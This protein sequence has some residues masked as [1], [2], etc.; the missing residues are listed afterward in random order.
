MK[1]II[2]LIALMIGSVVHA[3]SDKAAFMGIEPG[4]AS[5]QVATKKLNAKYTREGDG[6]QVYDS[7]SSGDIMPQSKSI[8]LFCRDGVA[9]VISVAFPKGGVDASLLKETHKILTENYGKSDTGAPGSLGD[10]I[11]RWFK[12]DSMVVLNSP[13]LSFDFTLAYISR[14][15]FD[16][17]AR[18]AKNKER[19]AL[20]K[21]KSGL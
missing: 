9:V 4:K 21:K 15:Y 19:D 1:K 17:L 10:Y 11:A 5:C 16:E 6:L 7:Q 18:Y 20:A 8:Q 14:G 3:A 12:G 13:H 2:V